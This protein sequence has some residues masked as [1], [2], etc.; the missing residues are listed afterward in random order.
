MANSAHRENRPRGAGGFTLIELMVVLMVIAL[1]STLIVPAL[2]EAVRRTGVD[3]TGKKLSDLIR[4]SSAYAVTR[5]RMVVLNLDS[6]RQ[7]CWVSAY[8]GRLPWDDAQETSK[9]APPL[10]TLELPAGTTLTVDRSAESN[11]GGSQGVSWE[12]VTFR[13]N[14]GAENVTIHLADAKG[15]QFDIA[16]Y[17]VTG[18][19]LTQR[20][21]ANER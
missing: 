4:F 14:G 18:E 1:L 9:P 2:A 11:Y 7:K 19:I 13:A 20:D 5:H 15:G 6:S 3:D 21:V 10:A 8:G 16:V 12:T 17:G